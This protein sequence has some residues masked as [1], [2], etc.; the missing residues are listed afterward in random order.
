[1]KK[2]L[3]LFSFFFLSALFSQ[4]NPDILKEIDFI[5]QKRWSAMNLDLDSLSDTVLVKFDSRITILR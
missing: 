2:F 5:S 4:K 1:M 3:L